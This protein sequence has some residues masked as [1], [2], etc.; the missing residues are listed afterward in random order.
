MAT[1]HSVLIT[2]KGGVITSG[3]GGGGWGGGV[4]IE[5]FHCMTTV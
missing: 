1:M 2:C 5:G 4:F 3:G